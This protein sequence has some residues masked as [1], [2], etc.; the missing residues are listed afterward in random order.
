MEWL[1]IAILGTTTGETVVQ[2][3]FEAKQEC[4]YVGN[5]LAQSKLVIKSDVKC[6]EV[7]R[8]K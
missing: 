6:F 8:G 4:L 3:R 2:F 1:L 7:T 5:F